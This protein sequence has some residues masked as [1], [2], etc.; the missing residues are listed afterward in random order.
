MMIAVLQATESIQV[1]YKDVMYKYLERTQDTIIS[2]ILEDDHIQEL[3]D[4]MN[5]RIVK[6]L[7]YPISVRGDEISSKSDENN[8]DAY[9]D[10]NHIA[11]S[12]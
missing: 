11:I 7:Q 4:G 9:V 1:N 10:Y 6:D 2:H 8:G 12:L 5:I 3:L